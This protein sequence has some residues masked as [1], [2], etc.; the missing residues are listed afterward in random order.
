MDRRLIAVFAVLAVALAAVPMVE[1]DLVE[2]DTTSPSTPATPAYYTGVCGTKN[3][4]SAIWEYDIS[5]KTLEV[6]GAGKVNAFSTWYLDKVLDKGRQAI[7]SATATMSKVEDF[8]LSLGT[9]VKDIGTAFKG[10]TDLKSIS[11]LGGVTSIA[12]DAFS[13]CTDLTKVE[14]AGSV[15]TIGKNAFKG[16]TKLESVSFSKA[17]KIGESAF[18]SCKAL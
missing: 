13:G 16:C 1:S 4:G 11:D 7:T 2:G 17:T 5:E 3:S 10:V 12:D 18:D 14:S 15:T 6:S 8:D 9:T